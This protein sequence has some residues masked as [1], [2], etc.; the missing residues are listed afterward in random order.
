[1]ITPK[2]LPS[3]NFRNISKWKAVDLR[4]T[5]DIAHRCASGVTFSGCISKSEIVEGMAKPSGHSANAP[6]FVKMMDKAA[7]RLPVLKRAL[8]RDICNM[9]NAAS[10]EAVEEL[11]ADTKSLSKQP[12][13]H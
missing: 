12:P 9:L 13:T 7:E 10:V 11:E 1:M 6:K 5:K 4:T 2:Q 3:F 8:D